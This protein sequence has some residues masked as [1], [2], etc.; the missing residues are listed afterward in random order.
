MPKDITPGE[1][2]QGNEPVSPTFDFERSYN[3]LRPEYT[4]T[5]QELST[6]REALSEYEQLFEAL[7]DPDPETQ[8]AAIAALGLELDTGSPDPAVDEFADPLEK[9]LQELRGVVDE[10][11]SAREL[12]TAQQETDRLDDLRNEFIG[13][14]IGLIEDGLK[15]TYGD[16]FSFSLKEEKVLG[17][18]SIQMADE[19]GVPDVEGAY[20]LLY[21]DGD[22]FLETNRQR[23]IASK[24]GAFTPP[25]GTTI[26]AEQR[27]KT[28]RERAAYIDQRIAAQELQQ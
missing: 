10:L 7:H 20:Q 15:P 12:E 1:A 2:S 21:G 3:E 23:W 22:S 13:D 27:P 16:K 6:T 9:E 8:A 14:A 19:R 18:L 24:T 28:A 17:D 4:R 26:P 25:A 5:T 11:R